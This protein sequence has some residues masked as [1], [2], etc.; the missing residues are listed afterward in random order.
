MWF[1]SYE[2]S[3]FFSTSIPIIFKNIIQVLSFEAMPE[4]FYIPP[5]FSTHI[6]KSPISYSYSEKAIA[7]KLQR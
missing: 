7:E 2:I 4:F 5:I 6:K 3:T 1:A